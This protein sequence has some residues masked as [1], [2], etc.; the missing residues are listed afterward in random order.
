MKRSRRRVSDTQRDTATQTEHSNRTTTHK[1]THANDA[2]AILLSGVDLAPP[3]SS[4][5]DG[6][7]S[8]SDDV[9]MSA[10]P[11]PSP[12]PASGAAASAAGGAIV[13]DTADGPKPVEPSTQN[14]NK[15]KKNV[16]NRAAG[17]GGA[18]GGPHH[19]QQRRGPSPRRDYGGPMRPRSPMRGAPWDGPYRGEQRRYSGEHDATERVNQAFAG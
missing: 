15:N 13:V 8:G 17:N 6:S 9:D 11:S 2:C 14:K 4:P 19:P 1:D 7:G 3:L 12:S 10:S 16:P 5:R 18:R